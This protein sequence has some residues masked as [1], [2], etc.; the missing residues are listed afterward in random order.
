MTV[1]AANRVADSSHDA[2]LPPRLLIADDDPV[3]Q[4]VLTMQLNQA[5]HI[6]GGA[7]DADQAIEMA[8]LHRPDVAIID[9]QMPGG[10]GLRATKEIRARA[11]GIAIVAL[12]SDESDSVVLAMLQAGAMT[13]VRKGRPA[14]E[15]ISILQSS[16][17]ANATL[18]PA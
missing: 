13:Y 6:V 7:L 15:L 16:I 18:R 4:S 10:G 3:M 12:S 9:V 1:D 2:G 11:P 14:G 8:E 17:A 5:F